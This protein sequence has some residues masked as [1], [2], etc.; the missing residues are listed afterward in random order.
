MV[1]A[2][3]IMV[4]T[5]NMKYIV[6]YENLGGFEDERIFDLEDMMRNFVNNLEVAG[7]AYKIVEVEETNEKI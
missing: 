6:Y 2:M 7:Q 3:T 5:I 4:T 1:I